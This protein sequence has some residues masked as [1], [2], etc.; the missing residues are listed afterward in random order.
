MGFVSVESNGSAGNKLLYNGSRAPRMRIDVG[1]WCEPASTRLA[2]LSGE[3]FDE[4]VARGR[5]SSVV[6]TP[7]AG[8]PRVDMKLR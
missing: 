3:I 4:Y 5:T 7:K 1:L 6:G 2:V 8:T